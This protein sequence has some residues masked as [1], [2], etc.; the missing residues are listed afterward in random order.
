[1]FARFSICGVVSYFGP[2]KASKKN[3]KYFTMVIS[4]K[5]NDIKVSKYSQ[6][7]PFKTIKIKNGLIWLTP[8]TYKALNINF[9]IA[10]NATSEISIL[11]DTKKEGI[12]ILTSR[13]QQI[14]E[15]IDVVAGTYVGS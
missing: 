15:I 2:I 4:D 13:V 14:A 11:R 1:L 10:L 6:M 3:G 7:V 12:L 5:T 9:E 8:Y